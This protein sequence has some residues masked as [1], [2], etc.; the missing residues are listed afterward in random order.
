VGASKTQTQI[1]QMPDA[2]RSKGGRR[3]PVLVVVQGEEIGRRYLLN[4]RRLILG[5]EPERADLAIADPS[6]SGKHALVVVDPEGDRYGIIDLGSRNGT[7][8][9]GNPVQS[10]GMRDGD[11]I[12]VG[13]TVL[14]FTFHDSIEEQFHG[15]LDRLM[16]LD[17]LTGLYVRRWFD[18]E[19]PRAFTKARSARRRLCVAMMDMD[20]IKEVNDLHGHQLGSHCISEAGKII[21]AT[22]PLG[23]AGARF[24]GDEFVAW[25]TDG[26]L[27]DVLDVAESIRRKIDAFEFRKGGVVVA[28]TISIGVAA[29]AP[30]VNGPEE[31]LRLADDALYRAKKQGRNTVSR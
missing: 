15:E 10:G 5:R 6:V 11:K 31:L 18:Q 3:Q 20:G 22:L 4:E 8:V 9:N 7:Y 1:L 21:K 12:F 27:E 16:H 23:A 19:Y 17:S 13:A 24:G 29:L 14:K 2:F 25:F 30:D 26:D 28:P